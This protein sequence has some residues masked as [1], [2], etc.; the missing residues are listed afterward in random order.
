MSALIEG[1]VVNEALLL[2]V[3]DKIRFDPDSWYQEYW[4]GQTGCGT[5]A[6][7]AGWAAMLSGYQAHWYLKADVTAPQ[8][9]DRVLDPDDPTRV[10]DVPALA[11]KLLGLT[12]EERFA[13][14]AATNTFSDLEVLTKDIISGETRKPGWMREG[15]DD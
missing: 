10:L 4:L 7:F 8:M 11:Q 12:V 3:L 1:P 6:C 9:S 13:L 2:K 14:F 15:S 5:V